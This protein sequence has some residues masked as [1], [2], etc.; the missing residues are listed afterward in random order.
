M[1]APAGETTLVS[2]LGT[3][4]SGFPGRQKSSR[5]PRATAPGC[6]FAT[7]ENLAAADTDGECATFI[8]RFGRPNHPRLG[9]RFPSQRRRLQDAF[10]AGASS[11]GTRVFIGTTENLVGGDADGRGRRLR[12]LRRTRQGSSRPPTQGRAAIRS[13]PPMRSV[14]RATAPAS[15]SKP[16]RSL[17]FG[18]ADGLVDVYERS[19]GQTTLISTPGVGTSG[20][21]EQ[22]DFF[23]ASSDGTRVFFETTENLI[24]ADADGL[25][26]IYERSSGQTTLVSAPGAS[27]SGSAQKVENAGASSDGS[28]VFFA[29]SE[30]LVGADTDG[31]LDVYERSGGQ[32]T[33]VSVPGVGANPPVRDI[34]LTGFSSDGTRAFLWTAEN[35]VAADTDGSVDIYESR[36]TNTPPAL[37]PIRQHDPRRGRAVATHSVGD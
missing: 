22:A 35:L 9:A 1:S 37:E 2:A 18:D 10:F 11:D 6:S 30:N 34:R 5:V 23:A 8:K 15:F 19:G 26:D 17:V 27:A 16:R 31:L 20:D 29:T 25:D 36:L 21:A 13:P 12:A 24:G 32:T 3:G 33:L 28:R 7:E 4:A 14:F